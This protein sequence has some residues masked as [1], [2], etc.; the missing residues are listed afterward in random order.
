MAKNKIILVNELIEF[1]GSDVV[2]VFGNIENVYVQH[3]KPSESVD[4][5]TLDWIDS[6]KINKQIIAEDSKARVVLA[7][8]EVTY[9]STIQSQNKIL[10]LVSNPKLCLVKIA[11]QFFVE[12]LSP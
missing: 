5:A 11:H 12:K 4:E 1:L 6:K 9:S 3:L 7:D 8:T 2:Q 10:L